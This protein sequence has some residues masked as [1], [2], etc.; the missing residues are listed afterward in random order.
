MIE[1]TILHCDLDAFYASVEQRD[2]PEYRGKPVIVGGGPN[3]RGVVSAAS[4]E[5]RK[6]GVHSAMPLRQAGKLCPHGIF[7]PGSFAAYEAASDAVMALF[8][9]RTPLVEPISLDEAF[10]DITG[11]A[12]LFGG[13]EACGR[14]LKRAVREQVGLVIS[15]G[16]APNKLCAKV[17][18]DLRKPD[19]FVVVPRGGEAAFLAPLPLKRLWGVGPKTQQVLEDLGMRTIG[20]LANAD[21][22]LLEAKLGEHGST[23][24]AR[25]NGIDDDREVVAD[26]GDPKSIGHAHTFDRDTLDRAQIESTLLRLS[27]GV[28]TRLR[29]HELRG[30]TITLQLRVA[31]FETR[32]RQRTLTEPT[33]DDLKIYETARVLLRE[34]LAADRDAGRV[35][36]V[37]LVG[38]TASGLVGGEQLDLFTGARVSRL[39][40]ALDAV[41]AKFGDAALDRASARDA[42]GR[43]RFSDRRPR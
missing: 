17:A 29:K 26:P 5:A 37:R 1:R 2:H 11:T 43:R 23:I 6:F 39:N 14:D 22:A 40:A 12:H 41:R 24:A 8:A 36:P 18:S 28:G 19:G 13:P 9:E 16:L 38:V 3:E 33:S 4:Y 7:V 31:P 25:A 30:R 10:L 20:D 42:G 15:V 34:A 27:E 21:L 32:T 35:S